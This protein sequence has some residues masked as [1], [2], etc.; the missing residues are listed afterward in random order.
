MFKKC[1]NCLNKLPPKKGGGGCALICVVLLFDIRE[2][3][4][5]LKTLSERVRG[6]KRK[7]GVVRLFRGW[8]HRWIRGVV[9]HAIMKVEWFSLGSVDDWWWF[10]CSLL[11]GAMRFKVI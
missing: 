4:R 3:R 1:S 2:D 9:L 10:R 8:C 5:I 11:C 6:R 7:L